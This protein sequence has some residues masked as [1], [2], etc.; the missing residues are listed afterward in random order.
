MGNE[1]VVIQTNGLTQKYGSFVAIRDVSLTVYEGEIF[2]FLGP[3]GAGKTTMIRTLLDFIRPTSGTAEIFGKDVREHNLAIH[4]D[5]GFLPSE[6]TLWENTTGKR[7]LRWLSKVY[8]QDVMPEAQKLAE[9]L[10][11]DLN[12]KLS[13]MSTGMKRKM[14]L[15]AALAH[16]PKLLIL[17]EPTIGLDP[18]MQD[19]FHEMVLEAKAE[20]RTVFMSSHAL[21]EVERVCDRVGIIREGQLQAVETVE[22][23]TRVTFRWM[24][25]TYESPVSPDG[26]GDMKGIHELTMEDN[27]IRMKVEGDADLDA[28]LRKVLEHT[29]VD[30]EFENPSLE[31]IFLSFYG[32]REQ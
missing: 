6:L 21:Q 20:G 19:V 13:G 31:E 11:Y 17:D 9:R 24:T 5:I 10:Q 26:L 30:L 18:L 12:R 3:N 15:I 29:V 1:N 2:G 27:T 28:V 14:G 22:N 7:Y 32:R 4:R 25:V 16:R 23:L 8:D